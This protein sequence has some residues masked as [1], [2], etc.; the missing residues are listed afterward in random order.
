M[1]DLICLEH[2]EDSEGYE[3][4]KSSNCIYVEEQAWEGDGLGIF[5]RDHP[6][7]RSAALLPDRASDVIRQND[8]RA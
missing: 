3:T 1:L 4:S 7:L 8:L 5:F 6:S 2:R